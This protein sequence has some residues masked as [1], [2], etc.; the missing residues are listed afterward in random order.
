MKRDKVIIPEVQAGS[1]FHIQAT[2]LFL[3]ITPAYH[4]RRALFQLAFN[5][6]ERFIVV[7]PSP[8]YFY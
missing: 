3:H 7:I 1:R 5:A 2:P 6:T 8:L 4:S